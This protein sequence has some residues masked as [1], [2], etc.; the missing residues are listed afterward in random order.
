MDKREQ[1]LFALAARRDLTTEERAACSARICDRL[2]LLPELQDARVVLS[3]MALADEAD[4]TAVHEWLRARGRC[5]AF[6]RCE[7]GGKM[8]AYV[9]GGWS[10]GPYGIREPEPASSQAVSPE[11]IELVLAPCVAFDETGMRLGHGAGYYDRYLPRC[12][13]ARVWA[14]AFEVQRLERVVFGAFDRRMDGVATEEK[15]YRV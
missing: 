11:T 13:R 7:A 12:I 15:L 5:L 1:R 9:P 14:A 3:Y 8:T 4:L 2:L 6:P 10:E